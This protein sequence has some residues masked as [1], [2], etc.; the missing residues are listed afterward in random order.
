MIRKQLLTLKDL[1]E[2]QARAERHHARTADVVKLRA[3][4]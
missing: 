4:R 3:V 1:A 2:A